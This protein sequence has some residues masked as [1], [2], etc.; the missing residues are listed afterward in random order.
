MSKF[1]KIVKKVLIFLAVLIVI[2]FIA[3]GILCIFIEIT[4]GDEIHVNWGIDLPK[5]EKEMNI[6]ST[7]IRD[8]KSLR[9][10]YY[11]D[12]KKVLSAASFKKITADNI[13]KIRFVINDYREQL[14]SKERKLFNKNFDIDKIIRED[15]Y[16]IFKSDSQQDYIFL[17]L[18]SKGE[19]YYINIYE[20][21][22]FIDSKLVKV[23]K[24]IE[25]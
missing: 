20:Q 8:G 3:V 24:E 25:T 18:N 2:D 10:Y 15:N 1:E 17:I 19:L 6:Y 4:S 21:H 22:D 5:H 23:E 14:N 12:Y 7:N 9:I 11:D 16:Y 13:E